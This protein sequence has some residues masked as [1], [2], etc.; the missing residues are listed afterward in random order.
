MQAVDLFRDGMNRS[1][2]YDSKHDGD[3]ASNAGSLRPLENFMKRLT[4]ATVVLALAACDVS[5]ELQGAGLADGGTTN[6]PGTDASAGARLPS[7]STADAGTADSGPSMTDA[8]TADSGLSTPDERFAAFD[9]DTTDG[10]TVDV[11]SHSIPFEGRYR[12]GLAVPLNMV[13]EAAMTLVIPAPIPAG[14]GAGN[15]K[16][17]AVFEDAPTGWAVRLSPRTLN[18]S[19]APDSASVTII[20]TNSEGRSNGPARMLRVW[21]HH[22]PADGGAYDFSTFRRFPVQAHL[23]E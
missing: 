23:G 17:E 15:Y 11:L 6:P 3:A 9:F 12:E 2:Q 8:G 18:V 19:V 13:T 5:Q 14:S 21:A 10:N 7:P 1:P 4:L 20:I 22:I 16:L